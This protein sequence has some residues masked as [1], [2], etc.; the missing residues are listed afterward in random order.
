MPESDQLTPLPLES[1]ETVAT[2]FTTPFA[3]TDALFGESEIVIGTP[4]GVP[5]PPHP[6]RNPRV[7]TKAKTKKL[8]TLS[9]LL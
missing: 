3:L 8:R 7:P 6:T 5:L 9:S 4:T 2:M 1:L